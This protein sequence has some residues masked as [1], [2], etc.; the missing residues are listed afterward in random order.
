MQTKIIE[1]SESSD[2]ILTNNGKVIG[3]ISIDHKAED[4]IRFIGRAVTLWNY[5]RST[6]HT[7]GCSTEITTKNADELA[8]AEAF[9]E[10]LKEG[11]KC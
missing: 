10:A 8:S 6:Y 5:P 1:V 9:M 3:Y 4:T 2:I 11:A 7:F